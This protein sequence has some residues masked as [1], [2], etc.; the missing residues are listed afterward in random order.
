MPAC[1]FAADDLEKMYESQQRLCAYSGVPM[2]D[3]ATANW[4]ASPE[5]LVPGDGG[6]VH[7]NLVLVAVEFNGM[8]QW[9]QA[10][11]VEALIRSAHDK[12]DEVILQRD[13]ARARVGRCHGLCIS[14][15]QKAVVP[16]R[17]T[18]DG[19]VLHRCLHC[20]DYKP[21]EDFPLH[22][23][24]FISFARGCKEC[25]ISPLRDFVRQTKK[26]CRSNTAIRNAK[27][28]AHECPD[29]TV[30]FLLDLFWE[31]RGRCAVSGIVMCYTP[32]AHWHMSLERIVETKGY[33][34][35][36]VVWVCNEFNTPHQQ[37]TAVKFAYMKG[38]AIQKYAKELSEFNFASLYPP[39][40]HIPIEIFTAPQ[41]CLSA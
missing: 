28:R 4:M 16:Q 23:G 29:V 34:K 37:W 3:T 18:P 27:N 5:R 25:Y 36:N 39:T 7:G 8:N 26:H 21:V 15:W 1:E 30:D 6:Y 35:T 14:K 13:I 40:I 33:I 41:S 38:F 32:G 17:T 12:V 9:S 20:D 19:I 22:K 11:V 31:Q 2:I 10:K 24:K